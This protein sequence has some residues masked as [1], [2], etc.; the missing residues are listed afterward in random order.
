MTENE[1]LVNIV[2]EKNFLNATLEADL[3][4]VKKSL[5]EQSDEAKKA[6]R[7]AKFASPMEKKDELDKDA[8]ECRRECEVLEADGEIVER[9]MARA[10]AE[11]D[12][13][14]LRRQQG[15]DQI[16]MGKQTSEEAV[17]VDWVPWRKLDWSKIEWSKIEFESD[18]SEEESEKK[19]DTSEEESEEN[20]QARKQWK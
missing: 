14:Q 3:K 20:R 8:E 10:K 4:E 12:V 11:L 2:R 9:Q 16:L 7:A 6:A 18:T 15:Q 19:S 13:A 1:R 17:E 5:V